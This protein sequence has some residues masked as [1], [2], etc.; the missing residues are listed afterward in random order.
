MKFNALIYGVLIS[1]LFMTACGTKSQLSKADKKFEAGE[2]ASALDLYSKAYGK[3]PHKSQEL[4][5]RVAFNQGECLNKLNFSRAEVMYNRAVRTKYQDSI[6][7]LKLAQAQHRN[8]KY[9]DA[10]KNYNLYLQHDSTSVLALNGIVGA[11]QTPFWRSNPTDYKVKRA[12]EFFVR[13]RYNFTPAFQG[14]DKK[15]KNNC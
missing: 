2:Y 7:Y 15:K 12:D 9:G 14:I 4:K 5:G 11:N 8:A 10:L 3:I 1:L 6:V 13:N